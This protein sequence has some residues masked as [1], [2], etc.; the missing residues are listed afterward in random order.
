MQVIQLVNL[1]SAIQKHNIYADRGSFSA[2]LSANKA[3]RSHAL[4][5]MNILYLK[6]RVMNALRTFYNKLRSSILNKGRIIIKII[7][8]A[9][10]IIEQRISNSTVLILASKEESSEIIDFFSTKD[11]LLS[12]IN[13]Y[14]RA[15]RRAV[16]T[17]NKNSLSVRIEPPTNSIVK[18]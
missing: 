9:Q 2:P 12:T 4:P 3:Q 10:E 15:R 7:F 6:E 13:S 8:F 16:L 1:F 14:I 11:H 5:F 18:K 17:K